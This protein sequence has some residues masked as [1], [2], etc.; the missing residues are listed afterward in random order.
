MGPPSSGGPLIIQMLN[1]LENFDV[2]SIKRNSTEFVHMLTEV[3]RLAFA[4]RAIHLGDPDFYPSPVPMLISKEYAKKRLGLVSMDKATPSTDIA[5]GTLYPESTETT[6]YS[7]M[8]KF[9]NTVGITTTINLSYGNKKIVDGAGFLLNNE[10][11]DFATAPGVQN[12]FG[13]IGYEANSI[14][15]AK[16]PLSSMSPTIIL[17]QDGEPLMTIGAAGGSRIITSVLQV[18]ISVI[19]HNLD[20]QEAINLGRTHSQ[21]I[22]DVVRFEGKNENN[23]STN[24]FVPSLNTKQIE[25]LKSL[26]HKFEDGNV[27]N[28]IYYLA[29]AHGIMYKKG[30]FITG[31]DWRGNG[32]ISDGITY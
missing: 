17:N 5:A 15:P 11:D 6:H 13:L 23:N 16:R 2:A 3:Q 27:E 25:E 29:R 10:M 19:D 12:A 21:W 31:V 30:Q 7:A 9:G 1:M 18:I 24:K 20:I 28:G 26:N 32:E 4:D 22:P 14:K 8:D